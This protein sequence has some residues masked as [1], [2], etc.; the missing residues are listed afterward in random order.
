VSWYAE[1]VGQHCSVGLIPF[2]NTYGVKLIVINFIPRVGSANPGLKIAN[3]CGGKMFSEN[4]NLRT[5]YS[6]RAEVV[7]QSVSRKA[8]DAEV[9]QRFLSQAEN[10]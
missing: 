4:K 8:R 5:C 3:A 9:A 7:Q 1:G 6:E 10:Y 2:A